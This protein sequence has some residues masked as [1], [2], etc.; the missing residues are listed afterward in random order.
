[1]ACVRRA[2]L[3]LGGLTMPLEDVSAG[4]FCTNLDLGSPDVRAVMTTNPDR[5]G[6]TDRTQYL[7]ARTVEADIVALVGAGA[8]IDDVA[9]G[10]APFMVP[11]ARPVLHYVLD[12]PGATERVLTLR[13]AQYGWK[14]AG[15]DQRDIVLQWVAADPIVR[16]P[17]TSSTS[18]YAGT[19]TAGRVYNLA[20][21]RAYPVG[22]QAPTSGRVSSPGDIPVRP[23]VRIY[24]P[25]SG[26]KVATQV[27]DASGAAVSSQL[28]M[29]FFGS[30]RVDAGHWLDIDHQRHTVLLDS[31]PAQS[32][33]SAVDWSKSSWLTVPPA[34]GY[35]TITLTGT[36]TTAITQCAAVWQDGYLS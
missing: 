17:L 9:D 14:I 1:M 36:G 20:F 25:I 23:L 12:R 27:V 35:A 32:M 2:W 29:T 3:T 6:V 15:P 33:F 19:G 24:G 16:D 18:S 4:Y 8:R 21:A 7:G 22:T 31:D 10:F 11:S 34:P 28:G 30:A 5:D 13:A 26:P